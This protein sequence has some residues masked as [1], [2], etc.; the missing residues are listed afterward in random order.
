MLSETTE[1]V[2]PALQP[3]YNYDP[4]NPPRYHDATTYYSAIFHLVIVNPPKTLRKTIAAITRGY[5]ASVVQSMNDTDFPLVLMQRQ[6]SKISSPL[7]KLTRQITTEPMW[8]LSGPD[9]VMA[10]YTVYSL[11]SEL[12]TSYTI[13]VSPG[14]IKKHSEH[15]LPLACCMYNVGLSIR[16]CCEHNRALSNV[17][18]AHTPPES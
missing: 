12:S 18:C 14:Q 8:Y 13:M 4:D 10:A 7:G 5:R 15:A 17:V 1:Q 2:H 6:T 3:F 11:D 16:L 9:G